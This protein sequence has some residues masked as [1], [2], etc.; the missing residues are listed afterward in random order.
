MSSKKKNK[1]KPLEAKTVTWDQE[2]E[3][4]VKEFSE[5]A[6]PLVVQEDAPEEVPGDTIRL[7]KIQAAVAAPA[8][9]DMR[10][11]PVEEDEPF[12]PPVPEKET[13]EPFSEN[14]E[15]EYDAPMGDYTPPT[16]PIVFKPKSRLQQL[17]AKL[18]AGP[19][20][21]YYE[22]SEQGF[23][24][25][26][27]GIFLSLVIFAAA[28]C[29]T[30]LYALGMVSPDRVK[31]LAYVQILCMLLSGL[32]G[33]YRM[34]EG[35]GDILKLRFTLNTWLALSFLV[36]CVDGVL[37][38]QQQRIS[39]CAVFCLEIIMAQLATYHKRATLLEQMDALR[40]AADLD[41]LV[42]VADYMDGKPGFATQP[43]EP[44]A[45]MENYEEAAL[46]E[47]ILNWYGLA[48]FLICG[49]FGLFGVLRDGLATGMQIMA[50]AML[51]SMPATVFISMTR[52][53]K[54]LSHRLH[55]LGAVLCGW[56][57]IQAIPRKLIF[58]LHQ[59]DLL[60]ADAIKPNGMKFLG[61]RNP[62]TVVCYAASLV[63]AEGGSLAPMFQQ[64]L[65]ARNGRPLPVEALQ[66]L[67]GGISGTVDGLSILVGTMEFMTHK[68]IEIPTG[69][70]VSQAVCISI[71]GE[72]AGMF[73]MRYS[74]SRSAMAGLRS[75]CGYR[76]IQPV[77]AENDFL[78]TGSFLA[79]HMKANPKRL[80]RPDAQ[81]RTALAEKKPAEDAVP[82]ALLTKPGLAPRAFALTGGKMLRTTWYLGMVIHLLGGILGLVAAAMLT[83][84]G[85]QHLLTPGNL[86]L[87][88]LIWMIPGFLVTQWTSVV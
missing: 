64:L 77:L 65:S 83:M 26:Q 36:C 45:F 85:A 52:P 50:G 67:E 30:V 39:C 33:C 41:A 42:G 34:L 6:L 61:Q 87:Y 54:L 22:L 79:R 3:D 37:C 74:R 5:D 59:A 56:K 14:W 1:K 32:V 15:P 72:L 63:C 13:V 29:T 57:G 84:A 19:E 10:Y 70:K 62:D 35:L 81:V 60:P 9:E 73:A 49:M 4:I 68:G 28:L 7:D 82:V 24:K 16:A 75:L 17:R 2:L 27:S 12:Q 8:A 43:G 21:K 25:L 18:V 48:S 44:E 76:S 38:L 88:S 55:K 51:L 66:S 31:L 47:K 40:K 46:P 20:R 11:Q 58:P 53:E 80:T 71:Q 78:F 86:L 69:T 23:G